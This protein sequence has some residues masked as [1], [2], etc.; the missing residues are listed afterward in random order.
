MMSSAIYDKIDPT[1]LAVF[2]PKVVN[3]VRSAGFHGPILTDD[4]GNAASPASGPWL[5][6]RP[7]PCAPGWT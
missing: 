5:T 3:L 7:T 1:T 6:A 4:I 2:S